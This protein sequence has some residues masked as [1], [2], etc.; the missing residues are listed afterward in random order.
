[1]TKKQTEC[2]P[3]SIRMA[4]ICILSPL[5]EKCSYY[6]QQPAYM[7]GLSAVNCDY[8]ASFFFCLC[9]VNTVQEE[10]WRETKTLRVNTSRG[11]PLWP[12]ASQHVSVWPLTV[13][14]GA[15]HH[16]KNALAKN[17][18]DWPF[19][20]LMVHAAQLDRLYR[21]T[22]GFLERASKKHSR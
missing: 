12:R 19:G 16:L 8:F 9:A 5:R 14:G 11:A 7:T 2:T 21:V 1:M 3:V 20:F 15:F 4:F 22:Q 18:K 17:R 13:G 6:C 10:T